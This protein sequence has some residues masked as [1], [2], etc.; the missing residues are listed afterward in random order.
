MSDIAVTVPKNFTHPSCPG[1][2]GMAAWLAEGDQ[3]GEP[4]SGTLWEFT[5]WGTTPRID[6]GDRVYVVCENRL[7]GYSPLVRLECDMA[8]GK[9]LGHIGLI[10]GGGAVACTIPTPIRGFRG[11]RYRWWNREAEVPLDLSEYVKGK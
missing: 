11:W 10:R 5:T 3:P 7:V 8:Y 1:K 2:R 4:W 9:G 6:I